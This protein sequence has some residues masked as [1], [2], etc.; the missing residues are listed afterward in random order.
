[1]D[2]RTII[3]VG[4]TASTPKARWKGDSP[5]EFFGVVL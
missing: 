1:M 2:V 5:V 3:Y 4:S